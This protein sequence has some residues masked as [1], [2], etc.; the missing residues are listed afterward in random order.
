MKPLGSTVEVLPEVRLIDFGK[1]LIADAVQSIAAEGVDVGTM[2]VVEF[3]M[4]D[5]RVRL[6]TRENTRYVRRVRNCRT[7]IIIVICQHWLLCKEHEEQG[8]VART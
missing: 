6:S 5:A 3:M 2:S 1:A 7:M 4:G 8:Y